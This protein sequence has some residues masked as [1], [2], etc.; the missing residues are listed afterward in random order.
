MS[1]GKTCMTITLVK[2]LGC[3]RTDERPAKTNRGMPSS[4]GM[5]RCMRRASLS[6]NWGW[7]AN[8]NLCTVSSVE[9]TLTLRGGDARGFD[10]SEV[11]CNAFGVRRV[12]LYKVADTRD[13]SSG[14]SSSDIDQIWGG[15][16][17]ELPC[18]GTMTRCVPLHSLCE[19]AAIKSITS[20][21]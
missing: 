16:G 8:G 14:R 15:D 7:G 12:G 4:S 17:L 1:K 5:Q 18:S 13:A 9:T 3:C 21:R 10:G 19:R 11:A 20:R 6:M 2:L